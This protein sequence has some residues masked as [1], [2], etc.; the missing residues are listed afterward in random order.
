MSSFSRSSGDP[1]I[2]LGRVRGTGNKGV[3]ISVFMLQEG[4]DRMVA[5]RL[6][7]VLRGAT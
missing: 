4:E 1:P 6:R 3:L 5:G 2:A 7:A